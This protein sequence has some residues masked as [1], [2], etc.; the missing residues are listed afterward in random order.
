MKHK[1][2]TL[3]MVLLT[4]LSYGQYQMEYLTR[5]VVAARTG[6]NNFVSWRWLG[7]EDD[8]TFN[9]YRN[10]TKVNS[11]PLKVTN[12]TDQ[13]AAANSTYTVRAIV[14]NVEQAPSETANTW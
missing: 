1:I 7:T 6:N 3:G 11:A 9:L 13:G 10:G 4:L 14:N 2:L 5:G 8:I 12:Y